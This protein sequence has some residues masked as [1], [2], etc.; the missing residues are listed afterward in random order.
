MSRIIQTD[1]LVIVVKNT[2]MLDFLLPVLWKIRSS[3]KDVKVSVL[4]CQTSKYKILRDTRY[5]SGKLNEWRVEEYDLVDFLSWPHRLGNW[6]L[7]GVLKKSRYDTGLMLSRW[8]SIG[9]L[10][11]FGRIDDVL[12]RYR[13]PAQLEPD[14]AR[15]V[16]EYLAAQ[17]LGGASELGQRLA[18]DDPVLIH[19]VAARSALAAYCESDE[20][21]LQEALAAIPFRSM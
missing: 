17:Y 5:Y 11:R 10:L 18:D 19:G 16:N 7:R 20:Q 21:K 14:V 12:K 13:D 6:L 4:Y 9:L 1:I 2:S 15:T 8:M 3:H